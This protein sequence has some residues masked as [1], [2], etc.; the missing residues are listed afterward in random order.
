MTSI[1]PAQ[2]DRFH[3]DLVRLL[4]DENARLGIAVSGGPDS[5]ALLHLAVAACPGRVEVAT[6]DHGLR[7]DAAAEALVVARACVALGVSHATLRVT[8]EK[9]AS[10]QAAARRARYGALAA[11]ARGRGLAAIATAH[12]ADDQAETVLMRLT[13]GAGLTG[14]AGIRDSR[15]LGGVLLVRPV[16]GWR[17]AELAAI[18]AGTETVDDPSNSDPRHDRTHARAW[19]AAAGGYLDPGRLAATAAHLA[20]A[21]AALRWL[22]GEVIRSRVQRFDDGRIAADIEGLPREVRRRILARLVGEADSAVDGP[23]LEIAMARLDAGKVASLGALKL[24]PG[25]RILIEKAPTRR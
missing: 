25:R 3:V 17:R 12:H 4:P 2:R 1:S 8:V 11:W 16:L 5:M 9:Q 7:A 15:D 19:L 13:R 23:T 20:E 22:T 10:V 18:V 6:V 14:L 21:D 24:S